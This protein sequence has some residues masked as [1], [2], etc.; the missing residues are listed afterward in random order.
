MG[1]SV[2]SLEETEGSVALMTGNFPSEL[3]WINPDIEH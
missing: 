3:T 1:K 2:V